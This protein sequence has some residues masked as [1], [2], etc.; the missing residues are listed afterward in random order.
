MHRHK[1]IFA[2][3]SS[4]SVKFECEGGT[5]AWLLGTLAVPSEQGCRLPLS[6][7]FGPI[8]VFFE[9]LVDGDQKASLSSLSR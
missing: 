5:A 1:N 8:R 6:Q 3:R 2:Y 7:E 9:P 4:A